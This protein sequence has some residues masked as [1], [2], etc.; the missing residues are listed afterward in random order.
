MTDSSGEFF[1]YVPADS[2]TV[3]VVGPV[4][5]RHIGTEIDPV[6]VTSDT[7]LGDIELATGVLVSG[8]LRWQDGLDDELMMMNFE[9]SQLEADLEP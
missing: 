9:L 2:Y 8:E 4:G 3:Q 6:V 5:G 7:N 1:L